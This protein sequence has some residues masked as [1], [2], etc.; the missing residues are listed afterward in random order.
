MLCP[1]FYVPG[2]NKLLSPFKNLNERKGHIKQES[3]W[4]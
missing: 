4:N 3:D 1:P 2:F